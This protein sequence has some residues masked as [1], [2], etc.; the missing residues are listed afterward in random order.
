[1]GALV[2]CAMPRVAEW[3]GALERASQADT[4]SVAVLVDAEEAARAE[5]HARCVTLERGFI[6]RCL[7]RGALQPAAQGGFWARYERKQQREEDERMHQFY[8]K[9]LRRV[10]M[11]RDLPA[12]ERL[13]VARGVQEVSFA[14]GAA[15][16]KK[17]TK[18]EFM[19]IVHRGRAVLDLL[20]APGEPDPELEPEADVR[21]KGG[22]EGES[23]E[24]RTQR[25]ERPTALSRAEPGQQNDADANEERGAEEEPARES[26]P[27]VYF[28]PGDFFGELA[29]LDS[30]PRMATVRA[31]GAVTCLRLSRH[32]FEHV[33][34]PVLRLF[35]LCALIS[36]AQGSSGVVENMPF[37][38]CGH[39]KSPTTRARPS[40]DL[41]VWLD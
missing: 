14:D 2:G 37:A 39:T 1:M 24:K 41:A 26:A 38:W 3:W 15:I 30:R 17:G 25:Q 33:Q 27:P 9:W 12:A 29:L 19:F 35:P 32:S 18:G 5:L 16:V 11:L 6:A 34:R 22:A 13:A 8:T 23:A 36:H 28:T 21:P 40:P 10:P 31:D 7:A 4:L 20:D